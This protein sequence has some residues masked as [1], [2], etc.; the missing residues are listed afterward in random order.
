METT[1]ERSLLSV[2]IR[3]MSW[4]A[5]YTVLDCKINE[6]M[7]ELQIPQITETIEL[8]RRNEKEHVD[9]VEL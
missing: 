8:H 5:R 6:I 9:R 4:T 3:F 7:R 2:E 1:V